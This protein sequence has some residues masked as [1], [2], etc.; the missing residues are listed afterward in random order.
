MDLAGN[1]D[2]DPL[3]MVPD[4]KT[5]KRHIT[6]TEKLLGIGLGRDYGYCYI[7]ELGTTQCCCVRMGLKLEPS[8]PSKTRMPPGKSSISTGLKTY[9]IAGPGR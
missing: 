6:N 7:G 4:P 5:G 1:F 8:S 3:D 9:I 2:P